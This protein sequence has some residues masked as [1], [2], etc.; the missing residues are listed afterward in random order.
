MQYGQRDAEGDWRVTGSISSCYGFE[1]QWDD[2][3][4]QYYADLLGRTIEEFASHIRVRND[5]GQEISWATIAGASYMSINDNRIYVTL[6]S[7]NS[8]V[9]F[10]T[11]NRLYIKH[12]S[13]L[14]NETAVKFD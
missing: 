5:E 1:M 7:S 4:G 6:V 3:D 11:G 13:G 8:S 12:D 10:K 2:I 14:I 9:K